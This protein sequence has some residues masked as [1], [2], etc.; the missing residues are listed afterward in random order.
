M[1]KELYEEEREYGLAAKLQLQGEQET[2]AAAEVRVQ[3]LE[4]RLL[5]AAAQQSHLLSQQPSSG[6]AAAGR[7]SSD[8]GRAETA[9]AV[10]AATAADLTALRGEKAAL[11]A[12]LEEATEKLRVLEAENAVLVASLEEAAEKQRVLLLEAATTTAVA[13][14]EAAAVAAALRGSEVEGLTQHCL[15]LQQRASDAEE[16]L[17]R[18]E[19]RL[20]ALEVERQALSLDS[21]SAATAEE[22]VDLGARLEAAQAE[23]REQCARSQELSASLESANAAAAAARAE[24]QA[25]LDSLESAHNAALAECQARMD[26]EGAERAAAATESTRTS[27]MLEDKCARLVVEWTGLRAELVAAAVD[28]EAERQARGEVEGQLERH[29]AALYR[30]AE[31]ERARGEEGLCQRD[32]FWKQEVGEG[33][34][35]LCCGPAVVGQGFVWAPV[36]PTRL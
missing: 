15:E 12:S 5:V 8:G 20:A 4:Q 17:A 27:L 30:E 22:V 14:E 36:T 9:R 2:R 21:A 23:L 24:S 33:E 16:G 31:E 34:V 26:A 25:R 10:A 3:D 19:V 1:L 11:V 13:V 18:A 6:E 7:R 28:L 35:W 29:A 32:A